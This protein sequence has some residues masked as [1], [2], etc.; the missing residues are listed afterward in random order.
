MKTL[1]MTATLAISAIC[2]VLAAP[3]AA[4]TPQQCAAMSLDAQCQQQGNGFYAKNHHAAVCAQFAQMPAI[5]V[6]QAFQQALDA[7]GAADPDMPLPVRGS[8][9]GASV[10]LYC[11]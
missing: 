2:L 6:S 4:A 9:V 7:V 8:A 11:D 5:T 10:G 3:A 1:G